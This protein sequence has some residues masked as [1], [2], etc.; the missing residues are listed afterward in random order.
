[1][2]KIVSSFM[3]QTTDKF[4]N[5]I[6]KGTLLNSLA[7]Q[8][9]PKLINPVV[10]RD[11]SFLGLSSKITIT[12]TLSTIMPDLGYIRLI[13]PLDQVQLSS[14]DDPTCLKLGSGLTCNL[15]W[16][17]SATNEIWVDIDNSF[18][19][20][21]CAKNTPITIFLPGAVNPTSFSANDVT[22]T[23]QIYTMNADKEY[24]DGAYQNIQAFPDLEGQDVIVL[25]ADIV[26][27]IVS[28]D[29]YFR[30]RF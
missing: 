17:A 14:V 21:D 1:M 6:D 9:T 22:S 29:T 16:Y 10:K 28:T 13:I 5:V 27:P 19:T 25:A 24:I 11:S 3:I 26:I 18:C 7:T 15:V 23:W 30:I 20:V 8:I 4:G 12:F 2:A